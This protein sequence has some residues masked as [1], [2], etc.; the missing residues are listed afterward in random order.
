MA[1]GDMRQ[2]YSSGSSAL[3]CTLAALASGAAQQCAP[4]VNSASAFPDGMLMIQLRTATGTHG[5]DLCYYAH[6]YSSPDGTNWTSPVTTG[7][8]MAITITTGMNFKGPAV[9]NFGTSITGL[10]TQVCV[11]ES[12]ANVFGG[13]LPPYFG[14]VIENKCLASTNDAATNR[15]IFY[16]TYLN[17]ATG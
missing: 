11:I 9:I 15:I 17:V 16:P 1:T 6:F 5:G 12:V 2:M 13:Q 3:A 10:A 8:D 14:V 4:Y 7:S